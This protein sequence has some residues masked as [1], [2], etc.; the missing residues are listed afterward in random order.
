[1]R[2]SSWTPR[3][4]GAKAFGRGD[5]PYMNPEPLWSRGWNEWNAGYKQAG[6]IHKARGGALSKD[7]SMAAPLAHETALEMLAMARAT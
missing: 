3:E 4:D 5:P 7:G 1:M 6:A 2:Q